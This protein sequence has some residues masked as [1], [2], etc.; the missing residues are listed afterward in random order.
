MSVG[1][2]I[3][4]LL[5]YAAKLCGDAAVNIVRLREQ[6]P[7]VEPVKSWLTEEHVLRLCRI[8]NYLDDHDRPDW[9]DVIRDILAL[10]SPPE[11]LR[12]TVIRM[13]AAP[14]CVE[15][16]EDRDAEWIAAISAAGVKVKGVAS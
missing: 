13:A 16:I 4:D 10:S 1:V 2:D 9:A 5:T 8:A 7:E 14:T 12:P 6:L 15:I 11:V 3:V